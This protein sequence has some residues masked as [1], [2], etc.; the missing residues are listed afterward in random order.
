MVVDQNGMR[1]VR[2]GLRALAAALAAAT[3]AGCVPALVGGAVVGTTVV[4]TDRRSAGIQLEDQA[5]EAR[6]RSAITEHYGDKAQVT[7]SSYNRVVLLLGAVPDEATRQR[8]IRIVRAVQN[9]EN[10]HDRLDVG[11]G[12]T[13]STA[14]NDSWIS[15]QVRA[16]LIGTS[17]LPSNTFVITTY[18]GTVYLQGLVTKA[19]GDA[20][21]RVASRVRGVRQVVTYYEYISEAQAKRTFGLHEQSNSAT[22]PQS[23]PGGNAQPTSSLAPASAP[24]DT[25]AAQ[26]IPIPAAP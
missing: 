1:W 26:V 4:A 14:A 13:V 25:G 10:V 24:A 6:V 12:R 22:Q 20:A 21:A 3:L 9:V 16:N 7:P 2:P 19:E 23:A 11:Q 8:V 17:D 18:R 15:G 5:I